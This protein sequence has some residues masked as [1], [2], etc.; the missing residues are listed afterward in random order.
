MLMELTSS[1]LLVSRFSRI[2][3][4]IVWDGT[5][6][7]KYPSHHCRMFL[8]VT[9]E[10]EL[11]RVYFPK[12]YPTHHC[13]RAISILCAW[14][15]LQEVTCG[16]CYA[17]CIML[18][19][20][21]MDIK[22]HMTEAD[23][24]AEIRHYTIMQFCDESDRIEGEDWN[25]EYGVEAAKYSLEHGFK[26][27]SDFLAVHKILGKRVNEPWVGRWRK[28]NVRVGDWIAPNP[29]EVNRR[30]F[31]LCEELPNMNSWQA[32]IA[33]ERIHPFQDMNGRVGRLLWLWKR[34][35]ETGNIEPEFLRNFYYQTLRHAGLNKK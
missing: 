3:T 4:E 33:F 17:L 34:H 13:L 15:M 18:C 8:S 25:D 7:A 19:F 2:K 21:Y 9:L 24:R 30:M 12:K 32:Y 26:E 31:M 11:R 5:Y 20:A 6:K 16:Y 28:V 14:H 35:E 29:G 22:K 10:K 23:L 1:L 27:V